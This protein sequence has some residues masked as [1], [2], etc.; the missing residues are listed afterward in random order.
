MNPGELVFT[1][2]RIE[3]QLRAAMGTRET[4]A[5]W[6]LRTIARLIA[7]QDRQTHQTMTTVSV[8]EPE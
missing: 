8:V 5:G 2:I 4:V 6:R 1:K 7:D 3:S